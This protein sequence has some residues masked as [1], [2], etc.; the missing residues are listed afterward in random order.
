MSRRFYYTSTH[1]KCETCGKPAAYVIKSG[2]ETY[3][4]ACNAAHA[5]AQVKELERAWS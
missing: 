3:N 4:Y 1:M 2:G 5:Q